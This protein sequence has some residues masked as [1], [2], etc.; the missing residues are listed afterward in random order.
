MSSYV[1]PRCG[2]KGS[3]LLQA[4][5]LCQACMSKW[6]W[7]GAAN[8]VVTITP[9]AVAAHEVK[10]AAKAT[11]AKPSPFI[12][13]LPVISLVF[14]AAVIVL[15]IYFFKP[16]PG[17]IPGQQVVNRFANIATSAAILAGLG[18]LIGASV[19]YF[20]RK[21]N[22]DLQ[23][24]ARV[25]G[26]VSIILATGVFGTAVFCW[27]KT[28]RA[29]SLSSPSQ[30]D[31]LMQ[32][33]HNATVVIQAHDPSINQYRSAKREGVIVATEAGHTLVLTVPFLDEKGNAIQLRDVWVNLS[34]GRTLAGRFV[35]AQSNPLPLAIVAVE[36]DKSPGQV[37]FHP[38]AEAFIPGQSVIAVPN[39]LEGWALQKGAILSRAS[40]RT[41]LGWNTIVKTDLPLGPLDVGSAMYDESGRLLGFMIGFEP[42][43][44]ESQFVIV[45]SATASVMGHGLHGK[46][47]AD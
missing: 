40:R 22:Y 23:T 5:Q 25:L 43:S 46:Q 38:T 6:A 33:L 18:V 39:P 37:Q 19:F 24:S 12:R 21:N 29:T 17:G 11:L 20:A 9:E 41:N 30:A 10:P 34:D 1:C 47:T 42:G 15:L 14:S 44:R 4:N 32:R 3:V 2:N 35:W 16:A 27:T 31:D 7:G 8:Q 28:E 26:M 45:D 36:T 13:I